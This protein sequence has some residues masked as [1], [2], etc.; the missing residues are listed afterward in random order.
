MEAQPSIHHALI[1]HLPS[2]GELHNSPCVARYLTSRLISRAEIPF[3]MSKQCRPQRNKNH[4]RWPLGDGGATPF[5][6]QRCRKTTCRGRATHTPGSQWRRFVRGVHC[7]TVEAC[8]E[9]W[10]GSYLSATTPP[11]EGGSAGGHLILGRPRDW[12]M[13]RSLSLL[14]TRSGTAACRSAPFFPYMSC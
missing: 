1:P 9:P 2:R 8:A 11:V 13:A 4:L 12:S 10:A 6:G 5:L 3:D 14:C 7:W